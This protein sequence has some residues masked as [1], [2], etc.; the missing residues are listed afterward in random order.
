MRRLALLLPVD[1]RL[2]DA[3]GETE[4]LDAIQIRRLQHAEHLEGGRPLGS[5]RAFARNSAK[6]PGSPKNMTTRCGSRVGPPQSQCSGALALHI[7][8]LPR[9]A[10]LRHAGAELVGKTRDHR[11]GHAERAQAGCGEG[12]LQRSLRRRVHRHGAGDRRSAQPRARGGG[13]F[14]AQQ[15]VGAPSSCCR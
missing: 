11:L 7:A 15:R 9:A 3:I 1:L 8:E 10:F 12:D 5:G 4:R 2:A 14:H 13:V 6:H